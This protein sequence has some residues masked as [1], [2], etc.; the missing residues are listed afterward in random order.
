MLPRGLI[1]VVH[2]RAMPGDPRASAAATFAE[3]FTA[4]LADAAALADGGADA[5]LVENFGSGPFFKGTGAARVPAHQVA[6]M[7]RVVA[8]CV[9]RWT[10]PV[11]VNC[12]RNDAHAALGIA[13]ATGAAF[14]RVNVHV[15]AYVTDQGLIEGDAARTLRYRRAL[16]SD[17]AILA[18]VLVKH[19]AP[20]APIVPDVAT[21]DTLHRGDADGVIVSGDAT[22]A[23]IDELI[24]SAVRSG[25]GDA[26]VYL[27]SGVTP[28]NVAR[29]AP[30]ANGA[31]VGTWL[32]E[33]GSIGNP[34]EV[35]RVRRLRTLLHEHLRP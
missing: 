20:L 21:R 26:P 15:G 31:I 10:L 11:G 22:G 19:A 30:H 25:A 4:A 18:D 5:L 27:G 3:V 35:D 16:G 2:L 28:A 29:L 6:L 32:K 17:I 23:T 24:L 1:G 34:V 13:A 12:L 8:A 9:E 7:T 14:I 33:S